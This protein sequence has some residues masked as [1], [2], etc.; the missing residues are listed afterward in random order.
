ME[1]TLAAPGAELIAILST[2]NK[3]SASINRLGMGVDLNATLTLIARGAVQAVAA[4]TA[5]STPPEARAEAAASA[6]IWIYD[7][8]RQE[9]DVNSRVSAGEPDGASFDDFPRPGGLGREAA[10]LRRRILSYQSGAPD[11]H[12][13]KQ[14]AGARSLVCCPLIVNQEVVGVLYVYRCDAR[15]FNEIELLI[16]DNFVQLAAV[17]IY[18]GRQVGGLTRALARKVR[19]NDKLRRASELI[20]SRTNLEETLQEIL[21]IG[22]DL[23]AAQYGSFELYD[24]KQKLLVTKAL[25]GSKA[26]PADE[27]PLPVNEQ[28]I[29]GWVAA[30]RQSLRIG[31]L[32]NPQWQAIYQPLPLDREMRSELAVPLV[33]A[34]GGLEGVLNIE[35]PQPDAFSEEDQFLL[36]AL[37]TQAVIAIQEIRLLDTIQEVAQ[38]L[39]TAPVDD[40]LKHIL[41]RACELINVSAGYIWQVVGADT[42][43]LRQS[44]EAQHREDRLPLS[45]SFTGK[46]IKLRQPIPID[47]VRT[48]PDFQNTQLAVE[49]GWVSAIVV[50]LL[51]P[52]NDDRPVGSFSLYATQLRDFSDWDKKLLTCLA[53]HAAVA[54]HDAEQ[55]EQLK[56][57]QEQRAIAE[58]FAAVGDVGANLLHQL[59]NKF[60]AISVRVQGIEDKCAGALESWPYL[61]E[62][63]QEIARS[64]RQAMAIVRDSMAHLQPA[65][66]QPVEALPCVERALERAAPAAAVQIKMGDL[67]RLPRVLAGERQL[68]MVFYNLFD[69]AL[70]AMGPRGEIS[71]D[72]DWRGDEVAFT[73]A[74]TGPGIPPD[75]Q[76]RI[77]EF[78][79]AGHRLGFGLWWVKTFVERF[80]G[81]VAVQTEPGRGS[82]FTVWLPAER[83]R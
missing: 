65:K 82:T 3:I 22:L 81:R 77:F 17:A 41:E 63:L 58:T 12:P 83:G 54:I 5:S 21:S 6:V 31:N 59:N 25:A 15:R 52:N 80:G 60:G 28:S 35:S 16:L 30:R 71:I 8:V 23:T 44:T 46:A 76:P 18:H 70:K 20:S 67:R 37:A 19:E 79:A 38:M 13:L 56:K 73:V 57:T 26:R 66:P 62:N 2:L 68:E 32:Q 50:P 39:L 29:V 53:N 75:K 55:L 45:R 64:A 1:P 4:G 47:D 34:G 49:K 33:G 10:R 42:L 48:H 36:E 78:A 14:E 27:P 61:A 24:K 72:G 7:E 9:F 11:I 40:L 51:A 43:V 69:N 74:D